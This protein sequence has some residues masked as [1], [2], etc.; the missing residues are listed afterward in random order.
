MTF[1]TKAITEK[2]ADKKEQSL[3]VEKNPAVS[4]IFIMHFLSNFKLMVF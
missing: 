3:F 4:I 1:I 2:K